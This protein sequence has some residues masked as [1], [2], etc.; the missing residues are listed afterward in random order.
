MC[1]DIVDYVA[2]DSTAIKRNERSCSSGWIGNKAPSRRRLDR[3]HRST[4][5]RHS[6]HV[7]LVV[8]YEINRRD[9]RSTAVRDDVTCRGRS[10]LSRKSGD[11]P[12]SEHRF[13]E[14]L[15][16]LIHQWWPAII[17]GNASELELPRARAPD[18]ISRDAGF[19]WTSRAGERWW[20]LICA[21]STIGH[22]I[23]LRL[24]TRAKRKQFTELC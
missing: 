24:L 13:R 11:T 8:H 3:T 1:D 6:T 17:K 4:P 20:R 12:T 23:Q 16:F 14:F 5:S 2:R 15:S 18:I 7:G 10:S 9:R 21:P 19:F 22:S